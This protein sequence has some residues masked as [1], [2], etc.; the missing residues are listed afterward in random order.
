[1]IEESDYN[2]GKLAMRLWTK[3]F[4]VSLALSWIALSASAD[5]QPSTSNMAIKAKASILD[6]PAPASVSSVNGTTIPAATQIIDSAGNVWTA[7]GGVFEN[8]TVVTATAVTLL[9][10]DNDTIYQQDGAGIWWSW[11]G[12]RWVLSSTPTLV[13][14]PAGTSIPT[15]TQITDGSGNVWAVSGGAYENGVLVNPTAVTQLLFD[16]GTMYLQ[17]SAGIWW[18]WNGRVWASSTNPT[19][20]SSPAGTSIPTATQIT[21]GSGNVWAVIGGVVYEN[22]ALAGYSNAVTMLVYQNN[23]LFQENSAGSWW[24]WNGNAW[25]L[26]GDPTSGSTGSATLSWTPPT[27]NTDQTPLTN[28]AGYTIYYGLSPTALTQTIQLADPSATSYIVANLGAATY[29]FAVAAYSS[30]GWEGPN[31]T[32]VSKTIPAV[33]ND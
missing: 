10:Y 1:M 21:D 13:A 29:Y 20:A 26:S 4:G 5:S 28:L 23:A 19:A 18:S 15:A 7:S 11:N 24:S 3:A 12:T 27:Q 22:G 32:P 9:M 25:V 6:A 33:A 8:G 2:M 30:L 16:N 31:S 14:S 17:D